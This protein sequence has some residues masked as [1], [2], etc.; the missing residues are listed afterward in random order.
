MPPAALAPGSQ[1]LILIRDPLMW[2]SAHHLL[3]QDLLLQCRRRL[4]TTGVLAFSCSPEQFT[5]GLAV[6]ITPSGDVITQPY[7]PIPRPRMS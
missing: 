4:T 1:D 6:T 2:D 3:R 7:C 5:A